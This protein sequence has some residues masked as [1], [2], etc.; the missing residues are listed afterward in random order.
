MEEQ[1]RIEEEFREVASKQVQSA[2]RRLKEGLNNL[3]QSKIDSEIEEQ[4]LLDAAGEHFAFATEM[5]LK[6]NLLF[7]DFRKDQRFT[8]TTASKIKLDGIEIAC[9]SVG[10]IEWH[11][12]LAGDTNEKKL[13]ILPFPDRILTMIK[14]NTTSDDERLL[15]SNDITQNKS[16]LTLT[17]SEKKVSGHSLYAYYQLQSPVARALIDTEFYCYVED[18][19][20]YTIFALLTEDIIKRSSD[21]K[22]IMPEDFMYKL[23]KLKESSVNLRYASISL[24]N[25]N[26]DE[27]SF[28]KEFASSVV[29]VGEYRFPLPKKYEQIDF[30]EFSYGNFFQKDYKWFAELDKMSKYYL[31]K[32]FTQKEI[33]TMM[34]YIDRILISSNAS[35]QD[36]RIFLNTC[37]YLKNYVKEKLRI[38]LEFRNAQYQRIATLCDSIKIF[39]PF[40]SS[41]ERLRQNQAFSSQANRNSYIDALKQ[42][43]EQCKESSS[44][45]IANESRNLRD[46]NVLEMF[47]Q[48]MTESQESNF[49]DDKFK[50]EINV[51]MIKKAIQSYVLDEDKESNTIDL[52]KGGKSELPNNPAILSYHP[53]IPKSLDTN[54]TFTTTSDLQEGIV[55]IQPDEFFKQGEGVVDRSIDK[56]KYVADITDTL[57]DRDSYQMDIGERYARPN[58]SEIF[59]ERVDENSCQFEIH[60]EDSE[61]TDI[62]RTSIDGSTRSFEY[63]LERPNDTESRRDISRESREN[64]YI[65]EFYNDTLEL[66]EDKERDNGSKSR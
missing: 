4:E 19:M 30:S 43:Q 64:S 5:T 58:P 26:P 31:Q 52:Q 61:R 54:Q 22:T 17:A 53:S 39:Q 9:P 11:N 48:E 56:P 29:S 50:D 51:E 45:S 33:I 27:L 63:F 18:E 20:K 41:S 2:K 32:N 46:Y 7:D 25:I 21:G 16:F 1:E 35:N 65:K 13:K 59:K 44:K 3:E 47:G 62:F 36:I 23:D 60:P 6:S 12:I 57:Y 28:L 55:E 66:L 10:S 24:D 8:Q 15:L 40:S 37:L 49:R 14:A 34:Q 42:A 38:N